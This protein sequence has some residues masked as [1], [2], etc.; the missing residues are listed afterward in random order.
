MFAQLS[1]KVADL[2][3]TQYK[4]AGT[5]DPAKV[6]RVYYNNVQKKQGT[7]WDWDGANNQVVLKGS[8]PGKG[9]VIKVCYQPKK[10]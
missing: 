5:P 7:D 4:L 6:I 3:K 2:A 10:S 8:P 1:K 9:V